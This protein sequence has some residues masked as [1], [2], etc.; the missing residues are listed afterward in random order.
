MRRASLTPTA[1]LTSTALRRTNSENPD[2]EY[3][4]KDTG[5][6]TSLT[7]PKQRPDDLSSVL[8]GAVSDDPDGFVGVDEGRP[9]IY[10][11]ET[12]GNRAKLPDDFNRSNAAVAANGPSIA[13]ATATTPHKGRRRKFFNVC[14]YGQEPRSAE[15]TSLRRIDLNWSPER[16]GDTNKIVVNTCVVNEASSRQ[17][18]SVF[19]Q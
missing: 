5:P 11:K 15:Q 12:N 3:D 17:I 14:V 6:S 13:P 19:W 1:P 2:D 7:N 4:Y 9:I 8:T 10:E 18:T 16:V